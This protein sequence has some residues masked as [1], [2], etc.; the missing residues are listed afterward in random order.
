MLQLMLGDAVK[1]VKRILPSFTIVEIYGA[2]AMICGHNPAPRDAA[3]KRA[4]TALRI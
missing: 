3:A 2:P 1:I 4:V